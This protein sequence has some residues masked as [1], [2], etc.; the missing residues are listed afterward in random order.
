MSAK[1]SSAGPRRV[2]YPAHEG[3]AMGDKKRR[4]ELRFEP[5]G[6]NVVQLSCRKVADRCFFYIFKHLAE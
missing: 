6:V 5:T 4:N 2:G 1:H 3:K